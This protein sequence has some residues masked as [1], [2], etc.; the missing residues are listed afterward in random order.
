MQ[1]HGFNPWVGKIPQR[2]KWQP[3][4]VVLPGKFHGQRSLA[5]CSPW[6]PKIVRDDLATKQ[7]QQGQIQVSFSNWVLYN[8]NRCPLY[9]HVFYKPMWTCFQ[10][11]SQPGRGQECS[12]WSWSLGLISFTTNLL[13]VSNSSLASGSQ[14]TF[15]TCLVKNRLSGAAINTDTSKNKAFL[16]FT[17]KTRFDSFYVDDKHFFPA[18]GMTSLVIFCLSPSS[19][20]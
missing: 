16:N 9:I 13:L 7:Q 18:L 8:V 5:G 20:T 19:G 17:F 1:R 11:P 10:G 4:P 3:A 14:W 6:G 2:R 12:E 15:T